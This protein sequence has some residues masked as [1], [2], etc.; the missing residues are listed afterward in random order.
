M[1]FLQ[2]LQFQSTMHWASMKIGENN[3]RYEDRRFML[4]FSYIFI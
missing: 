4:V 2:K 1:K 3:Q